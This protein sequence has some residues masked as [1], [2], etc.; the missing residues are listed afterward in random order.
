MPVPEHAMSSAAARAGTAWDAV[1]EYS[2]S[3]RRRVVA[4]A[5]TMMAF[6]AFVNLALVH[7]VAL[8][9]LYI[10]PLVVVAGFLKRWQIVVLALASTVLWEA[11]IQAPWSGDYLAR[12]ILV[13]TAFAG[14]ALFVK[15]LAR[16][17]QLALERVDELKARQDLE[18]RLRHS[19]RLEAVG[20][21]AGGIAHDFNNLLSVI[22]GFSDPALRQ[23]E[24]ESAVRRDVAEVHKAAERAAA[25]TSQLLEFSR[26]DIL[27]PKVTDLNALVSN[28]SKMLL[29]LI[30]EDIDLQLA[31]APALSA[32]KIDAGSIDQVV[33]NLVVNARDA[34]P[35][36]GKLT[37]QTGET[38]IAEPTTGVPPGIKPG[39]YVT[40]AVQDTGVGMEQTVQEHLFE[41]FFTTKEAGKGTGL[42][43]STAYGIVKQNGGDIWFLSE[44]G[45]GTQFTIYLPPTEAPRE[46]DALARHRPSERRIPATV[47]LV[48]DDDMVRE[49][50]REILTRNGLTVV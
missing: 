9:Y 1:F 19:Q 15:E 13:A 42:G 29:R 20:R 28:I 25:L 7:T 26:R 33:M 3:N 43:L 27:Q 36:G 11:S 41:P 14:A 49:L 8:G 46:A 45:Q 24:P 38:E 30:G 34:M 2:R 6:I 47:L 44:R 5:A 32:V 50:A 21:L 39:R 10:I 48:E 40:L 4:A 17:Q 12:T 35:H 23:I 18:R 31:L 22:I 37:I 16:N